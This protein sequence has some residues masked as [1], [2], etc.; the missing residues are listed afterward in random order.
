MKSVNCTQ[1]DE[2]KESDLVKFIR[3]HITVPERPI[4]IDDNCPFLVR[5]LQEA[6][7]SL[8]ETPIPDYIVKRMTEKD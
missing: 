3:A 4:R 1:M 8:E 2:K 5:K 7:K 6:Y